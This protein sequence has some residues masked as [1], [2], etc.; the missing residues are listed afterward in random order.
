MRWLLGLGSCW[1]KPFRAD[2]IARLF[3]LQEQ[4]RRRMH[5]SG[6]IPLPPPNQ[7]K[8]M[9]RFGG[10]PDEMSSDRP[11]QLNR[12]VWLQV[13]GEERRHLAVFQALVGPVSCDHGP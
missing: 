12:V 2:R 9:P 7:Q 8:R 13:V 6:T 4:R 1:P 11:A 3:R 10:C 5:M